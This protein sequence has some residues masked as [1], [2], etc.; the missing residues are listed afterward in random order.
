MLETTPGFCTERIHIYLA[1]GLRQGTAHPD[2]GEFLSVERVP[3]EEA[4]SRVMSGVI[5]DGKTVTGLLMVSA[6]RASA[7]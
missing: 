1:T 3:L 7:Q 5:R 4:V 2:E 6:L